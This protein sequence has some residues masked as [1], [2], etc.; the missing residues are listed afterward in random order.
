MIWQDFM[1]ACAMYPTRPDFLASVRLEV[2]RQVKRLQHHP[3]VVI[4]A[5]NNE[6]EAAL[7]GN[8]YE[9]KKNFSLYAADFV[10]LYIDTIKNY[11]NKLDP[12]RTCLSS[13]PTN[14]KG[15]EAEGW[16][17]QNPYSTLYGDGSFLC[18]LLDPFKRARCN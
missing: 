3:S 13:S 1:F 14:G 16:I 11:V 18:H 10:K 12:S 5:A 7:R 15:S 2:E 6:N 17:A 9:T 4:W 8:W